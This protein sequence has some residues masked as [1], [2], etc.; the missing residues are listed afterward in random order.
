MLPLYPDNLRY[1]YGDEMEQLFREQFMDASKEGTSGIG[2]VWRSAVYDAVFLVGPA[3]LE[4]IRLWT[5]ATLLSAS[6]IFL[7]TLSFC[8]FRNIGVV[9]GCALAQAA[10][11]SGPGSTG[12]LV[13]ISQGHKMFLECTGESH[14]KPTVILATGR[15]L[16]AHQD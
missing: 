14:G 11:T 13:P 8:T 3:C 7:T 4:P 16:G 1:R 9:H 10:Q 2:R 12:D 15:G 6:A 5:L